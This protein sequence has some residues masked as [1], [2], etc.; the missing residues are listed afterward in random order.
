MKIIVDTHQ[1]ILPIIEYIEDQDLIIDKILISHSHHDHVRY[2]DDFISLYRNVE[3]IISEKTKMDIDN[4]SRYIAH[5]EIF[6]IGESMVLALHT[7]GHFFDSICYLVKDENIAFTGDTM[8]VGRTGRTMSS[9]SNIEDLYH[10]IYKI[11]LKLPLETVIYPGHHYGFKKYIS[12]KEN[13][14]YSNFF[15]CKSLS[16]FKIV[17]KNFEENR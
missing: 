2:L 11:L 17:M 10:S 13:I 15:K 3:V 9:G 7:P 6:F 1:L 12:L 5:N 14:F 16:E 8:F 4:N